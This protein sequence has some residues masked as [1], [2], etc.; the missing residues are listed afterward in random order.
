MKTIRSWLTGAVFFLILLSM[1]DT[2]I[3][4]VFEPARTFAVVAGES[5][6]VSGKLAGTVRP[7]DIPHSR[8]LLSNRIQ[9][10]DLLRK[11]LVCSPRHQS[12][13]LQFVELKG[14]L[15]RARLVTDAGAGP[16]DYQIRVY[17][18]AAPTDADAPPF[19][20]RL[21]ADTEQMRKSRASLFRKYA[22]T[23]PWWVTFSLLPAACWLFFRAWKKSGKED[24]ALQARGRGPIYRLARSK[25][26]W[27]LLFGL[28]A[29][30]G[31][32]QGEH[33]SV[34]DSRGR[35]TGQQVVAEKVL[36]EWSRAK[37]GPE[38]LIRPDD[39]I[40]KIEPPPSGRA[41]V[42]DGRTDERGN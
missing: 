20:V 39:L 38:A 23:D 9:D 26:G 2:F 3:A 40:C 25:D 35:P 18:A 37:I 5:K 22:G 13:D 41:A 16:G 21:F 7:V 19:T 30:H 11:L 4:A 32:R 33:L 24:E 28:G 31:I 42:D 15:W 8:P 10:P 29:V 17:Q 36:A 6:T 27:E 1:I 14:R 34:L 12:F